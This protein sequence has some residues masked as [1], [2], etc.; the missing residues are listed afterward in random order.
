MFVFRS[1]A[2]RRGFF[3]VFERLRGNP[4]TLLAF[5]QVQTPGERVFKEN[6]MTFKKKLMLSNLRERLID[7]SLLILLAALLILAAAYG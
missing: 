1:P 4:G 5:P 3:L 7:G 2:D 6:A